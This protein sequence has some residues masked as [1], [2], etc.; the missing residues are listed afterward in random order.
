MTPP[1]H[2][3]Y[4]VSWYHINRPPRPSLPPPGYTPY[5][6]HAHVPPGTPTPGFSEPAVRALG[7]RPQ[8]AL[9]SET[10]Y[11][12]SSSDVSR[13]PIR[14]DYGQ[15]SRRELSWDWIQPKGILN[16]GPGGPLQYGNSGLKE[17]L[18]YSA[19][20]LRFPGR[21]WAKVP[22]ERVLRGLRP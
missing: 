11:G 8:L 10:A 21:V 19:G 9:G 5:S 3:P 2:I 16:Q 14:Q 13:P 18:F 6:T 20:F 7:S 1:V 15:M 17:S 22:T 4:P 12:N